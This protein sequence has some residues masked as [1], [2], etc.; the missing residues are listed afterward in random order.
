MTEREREMTYR[1]CLFNIVARARVL[2]VHGPVFQLNLIRRKRNALRRQLLRRQRKK[3]QKRKV[4]RLDRRV[5]LIVHV[6]RHAAAPVRSV[7]GIRLVSQHLCHERVEQSCRV[8]NF[9]AIG[10]GRGEAEAGEGWHHDV[11]WL[12]GVALELVD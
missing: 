4:H 12:A 5:E 1:S 2:K 9:P 11:E 7:H 6:K 3:G 8:G 10:R